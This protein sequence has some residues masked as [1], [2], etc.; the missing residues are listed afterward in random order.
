[1]DTWSVAQIVAYLER[2]GIV[3]RISQGTPFIH[4]PTNLPNKEDLLARVMPH[5][6]ANR[7]R[8]V[9]FFENAEHYPPK[10]TELQRQVYLEKKAKEPPTY[11]PI[12][13]QIDRQRAINTF[14]HG[15]NGREVWFLMP[16]GMSIKLSSKVR[17]VPPEA[18]HI[19][20]RGDQQWTPIPKALTM[21]SPKSIA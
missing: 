18:T 5:I 6:K 8:V 4:P 3:I 11:Q 16:T 1:M 10:M 12:A 7:A 15:F 2:Y 19:C 21:H 20:F 9:A 17:V 13:K 14:I